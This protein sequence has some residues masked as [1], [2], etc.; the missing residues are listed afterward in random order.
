MRC[1]VTPTDAM[2]IKGD[3][4]GF[5]TE[6]AKLG[7][8]YLCDQHNRLKHDFTTEEWTVEGLCVQIYDLVKETL[9]LNIMKFLLEDKYTS[10]K[11]DG[12]DENLEQLIRDSWKATSKEEPFMNIGFS[13]SSGSIVGVGA[14]THIF[15]PDVAKALGCDYVVPEFAGVA[16]ALGAI[17]GNV[18]VENKVE[19]KPNFA[20]DASCIDSIFLVLL[21]NIIEDT[22]NT[23]K[24]LLEYT[25]VSYMLVDRISNIMNR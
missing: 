25:G 16:N 20:F 15:L 2:H 12:V 5:N 4:N 6:V 3:F 22:T 19:I 17:V 7:V 13:I 9:Y 8:S 21:L 14:P 11:K 24:I 18:R 1:G 10:Y 23:I